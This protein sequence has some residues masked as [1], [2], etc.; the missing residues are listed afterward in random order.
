MNK[1]IEKNN[2]NILIHDVR[3]AQIKERRK[4]NA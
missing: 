3:Q 1:K 2:N 4:A